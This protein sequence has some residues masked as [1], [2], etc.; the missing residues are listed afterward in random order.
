MCVLKGCCPPCVLDLGRIRDKITAEYNL[1]VSG[2][3]LD[4]L[5]IPFNTGFYC[6]E[7]TE[8][9]RNGVICAVCLLNDNAPE[10][11]ADPYTIT[12]FENTE[13]GTLLTRVQA[14]DA[15][16]G[17]ARKMLLSSDC[18]LRGCFKTHSSPSTYLT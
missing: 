12:V 16:A 13:P 15:D 10:F 1:L 5:E 14:T 17:I 7:F 18:G 9:G 6:R 2:I 11:S 4:E 3:K 8:S